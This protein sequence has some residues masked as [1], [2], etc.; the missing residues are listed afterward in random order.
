MLTERFGSG[1][2]AMRS[3]DVHSV[4]DREN[5]PT[6]PHFPTVMLN[7]VAKILGRTD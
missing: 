6:Y 5:T 7:E 2:S 4:V 3:I 1:G